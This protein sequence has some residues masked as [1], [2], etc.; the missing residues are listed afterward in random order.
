MKT[1]LGIVRPILF[2]LWGTSAAATLTYAAPRTGLSFEGNVL[3]LATAY[4]V[5]EGLL[6]VRNP[7][8]LLP[9][10]TFLAVYLY[11]FYRLF[12]ESLT[13]GTALVIPTV[14]L[15]FL[16]YTGISLRLMHSKLVAR[17]A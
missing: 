15:M 14:S 2:F 13:E 10:L 7:N 8:S 4:V 1:L 9:K 6:D 12:I 11:L 5:S 17:Q 16:V 3:I